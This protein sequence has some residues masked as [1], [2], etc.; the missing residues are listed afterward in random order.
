MMSGI[1]SEPELQQLLNILLSYCEKKLPEHDTLFSLIDRTVTVLEKESDTY[2]TK[3]D[4]GTPGGLIDFTSD[5]YRTQT[6]IVVPDLHARAEFIIKL[7]KSD[8]VKPTVLDA[9]NENRVIVICVGDGVHAENREYERW[10]KAYHDWQEGLYNGE[11]M[12]SEMEEGIATMRG[13]M[14]VKCAFPVN[15]HFLKGNH[16][17]IMDNEGDGDHSFRKFALEGEMVKDFVREVYGDVILHMENCFEK[18]LPICAICR[19]CGVSH[20]EPLKAYTKKEIINYHK[21][22][23]LILG[24]TWTANDEAEDDSVEK[25][26]HTLNK[27]NKSAA[28]LWFGG[29]R[30]VQDKFLLRQNGMYVQI[31][32]PDEMNVAVIKP[33]SVFNPETDIVSVTE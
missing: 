15:F 8:V 32:N 12:Q 19:K 10:M 33:D 29:H 25:L 26:F 5:E 18:A 2:R 27:K 9:L 6:I 4:D 20:A 13:V 24:L 14:A 3:A 22:P 16:E 1:Y 21:H 30:P 7:L 28:P 17:N 11:S 31:H 23:E